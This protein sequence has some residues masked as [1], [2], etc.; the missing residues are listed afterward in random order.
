MAYYYWFNIKQ[1]TVFFFYFI[2]FTVPL[3]ICNVLVFTSATEEA[4]SKKDVATTKSKEIEIQSKEIAVEKGEADAELA[5]AMPA[6]EA[7]REAL[8]KLEKADITEIRFKVLY[9]IKIGVLKC[10][11]KP[12]TLTS[13]RFK[14]I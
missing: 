4:T 12:I 6:V 10:P 7:A 13:Y 3:F 11:R 8:S 1:K 9:S 2:F 5:V 14:K